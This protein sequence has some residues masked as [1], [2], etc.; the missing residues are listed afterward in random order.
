MIKTPDW[1][2]RKT[3]PVTS[4]IAA[5]RMERTGARSAQQDR[6]L[7]LVQRFPGRTSCELATHGEL[8][9]HQISRR[10][11]ELE[12]AGVIVR[13]K[14]RQSTAT[15]NTA[16]TWEPVVASVPEQ[17]SLFQEHEN[18]VV[19][20]GVGD[21]FICTCRVWPEDRTDPQARDEPEL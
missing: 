4:H 1:P 13:G 18:D 6:V 20:C 7:Q 21:E 14:A 8:K 2:A 17:Q 9:H 5:E 16:L 19:L 10:L 12:S 15:G 11:P 3:D